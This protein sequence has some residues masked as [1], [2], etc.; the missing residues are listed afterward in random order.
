MLGGAFKG[1]HVAAG[2]SACSLAYYSQ[3]LHAQLHIPTHNM[4]VFLVIAM[5]ALFMLLLFAVVYHCYYFSNVVM[6]SI[7]V[8]SHRVNLIYIKM[9]L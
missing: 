2:D 3:V 9:Y 4:E 5:T 6:L 8:G 7:F 1:P